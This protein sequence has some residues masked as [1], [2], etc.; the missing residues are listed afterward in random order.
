MP[1][2]IDSRQSRQRALLDQMALNTDVKLDNLLNLINDELQPPLRLRQSNPDS[3]VLNLD[4][5]SVTTLD[6]SEGHS[7]TK[8]IQPINGVLPTFTPGTVT[9]PS[10]GGGS[11]AITA[12]GPTLAASYNLPVLTAGQWLKVL[13]A[14]NSDGQVALTFGTPG[15][16]EAAAGFPDIDT[17]TL[18][19]GYISLNTNG[20]NVV[21]NITGSRV[22]QFTGGGGGSG[23][24]GSGTFKNY[25]SKWFDGES[26]ISGVS[27]GGVSDTGNRSAAD[28][29]WASTNTANIT[30]QR[31]TG[32]VLRGKNSILVNPTTTS[33]TGTIFIETPTFTLDIPERDV[34]TNTILSLYVS[35]VFSVSATN[36]FDVILVRYNSAGVYQEKVPVYGV[37]PNSGATPASQMVSTTTAVSRYFGF[38]SRISGAGMAATDKFALR[39]RAIGSTSGIYIEDLYVGPNADMNTSAQRFMGIKQFAD[40]VELL[41]GMNVP[42][43][44]DFSGSLIVLANETKIVGKLNIASGKTLTVDSGANLV[45]VGSITGPGTL[46]GSGTVTSI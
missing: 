10:A 16:S 18:P 1:T 14:L 21:N 19:I 3:L 43:E 12:S 22:Y 7:R 11:G 31:S 4:A 17:G 13:F 23:G 9:F 24:T 42:N 8:T 26:N 20:S 27:N 32:V 5:I 37:F 15:A 33:G 45:T 29:V 2:R 28:A 35:F 39:I 44:L 25:L 41:E 36:N 6:G 34:L 46:A 40:E 38:T 30:V